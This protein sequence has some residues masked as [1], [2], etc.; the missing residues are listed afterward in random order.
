MTRNL[1]FPID[2]FQFSNGKSFSSCSPNNLSVNGGKFLPRSQVI[3]HRNGHKKYSV[4]AIVGD[5]AEA[6]GIPFID[7]T[8]ELSKHDPA[9]IFGDYVHYSYAG[10]RIVA[11]ILKPFF[12]RPGTINRKPAMAVL[13]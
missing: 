10:H 2:Q 6:E 9:A 7:L 12:N 4:P 11:G 13:P 3:A 8:P 1:S 5:W